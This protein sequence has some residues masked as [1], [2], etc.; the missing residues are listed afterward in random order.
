[1]THLQEDLML[2]G[3]GGDWNFICNMVERGLPMLW[4]FEEL[5][6]WLRER[7]HPRLA[8]RLQCTC[9]LC[10]EDFWKGFDRNV[11]LDR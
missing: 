6:E 8:K 9:S 3:I 4:T 1:M 11:K 2:N 5:R 7:G 10:A